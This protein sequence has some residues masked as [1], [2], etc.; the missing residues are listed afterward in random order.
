MQHADPEST[1]MHRSDWLGPAEKRRP[2][3]CP[4]LERLGPWS[5]LTLQQTVPITFSL[6]HEDL[7]DAGI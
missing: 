4:V 3:V 5:A 7:D 6:D 1:P 2:Y